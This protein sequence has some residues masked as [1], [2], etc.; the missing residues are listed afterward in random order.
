VTKLEQEQIA[1]AIARA[2]DGTSGRIGVRIIPDAAVDALGRAQRE[3]AGVGFNRHDA[4][5]AALILV[6]PK[7]RQ[8][9][10][11]G[12]RALHERVGDAFWNEIVE[13]SRPYFARGEIAGGVVHAV[14]KLGAA[15][16]AHFACE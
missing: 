1:T 8:F 10:V 6:A 9:A 12:D 13:E 4:A 16:R 3:F 7:A 14:E 11:V 5:N 15:L 2:E